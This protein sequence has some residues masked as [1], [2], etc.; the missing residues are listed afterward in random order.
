M[1]PSAKYAHLDGGFPEPPPPRTPGRLLRCDADGLA[2]FYAGGANC[3]PGAAKA[4]LLAAVVAA[5]AAAGAE[6]VELVYTPEGS[7]KGD[8]YAVAR[9]KPYQGQRTSKNRPANWAFL[10][11]VIERDP[12]A[13][14]SGDLEADDRLARPHQ[15]LVIWSQDKDLRM[16]TGC[17]H[18]RWDRSGL[19][20]VPPGAFCVIDAERSEGKV[21]GHLW[22]WLQ[23]LHG[24]PADNIPG[25]PLHAGK[26]VGEVAASR[27]MAPG[28]DNEQAFHIVAQAYFEAFG[29]RW[30]VELLEQAVLLWIRP[31][32]SWVDVAKDGRPLAPLRRVPHEAEA[33][34][35]EIKRRVDQARKANSAPTHG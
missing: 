26:P 32:L 5:Q 20:H 25:L 21:Y 6:A 15:D 9:R 29:E 11:G 14:S 2:Y 33:A 1:G 8:R 16:V 7:T 22:F 12:R 3:S 31:G 27:L 19:V 30:A 10:R 34:R 23:L 28:M 24:D 4:N 18:L 17:R 13:V 35:L